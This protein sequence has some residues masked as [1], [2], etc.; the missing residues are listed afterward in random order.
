MCLVSYAANVN[1]V[2]IPFYSET[3]THRRWL[4]PVNF[5]LQ[6]IEGAVASEVSIPDFPHIPH[7]WKSQGIRSGNLGGQGLCF[8]L[9]I[10]V[11][12]LEPPYH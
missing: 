2:L 5:A 8:G 11:F 1:A 4:W 12:A 10:Q 9:P 7:K 3:V 6:V